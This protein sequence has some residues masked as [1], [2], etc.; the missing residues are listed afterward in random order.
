MCRR[1]YNLALKDKKLNPFS[2]ILVCIHF[3]KQEHKIDLTPNVT[4]VQLFLAK[5]TVV[6]MY[7]CIFAAYF[8][9]PWTV[10]GCVQFIHGT[11]QTKSLLAFCGN[12]K[13]PTAKISLIVCQL[14]N[15]KYYNL[16]LPFVMVCVATSVMTK[17][18][19]TWRWETPGR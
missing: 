13:F 9:F 15:F 8:S 10:F 11:R 18:L 4:N 19:F 5:I 3:K 2:V 7:L 12:G 6:S 17:G 1:V 14:K 16:C